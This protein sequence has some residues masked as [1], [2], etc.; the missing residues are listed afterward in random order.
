MADEKYEKRLRLQIYLSLLISLISSILLR[1]ILA[2]EKIEIPI[3]AETLAWITMI[4]VFGALFG[5]YAY[6]KIKKK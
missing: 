1:G 5:F 2:S 4:F 6:H 3:Y